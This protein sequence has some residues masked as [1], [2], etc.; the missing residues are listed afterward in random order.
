MAVAAMAVAAVA[1][2]ALDAAAAAVVAAAAAAVVVAAAAAVV[3]AVAA[4]PDTADLGIGVGMRAEHYAEFLRDDVA[5]ARWVEV[6]AEKYLAEPDGK[7]G[8]HLQVLEHV[9]ARM[10]VVL[11]GTSM[12]LGSARDE[13]SAYLAR[14]AQLCAIIEPAMVSD[15]LCWTGIDDVHLYDLL[16]LPF[17]EESIAVLVERIG[18][19]QDVLGR[20]ILV[21]NLSTYVT[22]ASSEMSEWEFVSQVVERADCDLLLDINN[23]HVSC[24]N[25]GWDAHAYLDGVPHHRVRQI[26]L[27]GYTDHGHIKID[28]HGEP[29]HEP[30]WQLF[31]WYVDRHGAINPM[32]ERDSDVPPWSELAGELRR[33]SAIVSSAAVR[34]CA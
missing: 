30:V 9:R 32:I 27:A 31:R 24:E 34:R 6:N 22:F 18:R 7:R 33:M 29:V 8:A 12:S 4:V 28:S 14:L 2:D 13:S 11:H 25:H 19:A 20:R 26:H 17:V 10:P 16:P 21:E 5:P 23:V 1:A 15:H 3:A